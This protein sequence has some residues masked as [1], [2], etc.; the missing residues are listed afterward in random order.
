MVSKPK[1]NVKTLKWVILIEGIEN[2]Q[3][4]ILKMGLLDGYLWFKLKIK[5]GQE[6]DW[7][8]SQ[9]H[10]LKM[11]P[12][13]IIMSKILATYRLW[14]NLNFALMRVIWMIILSL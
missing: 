4:S 13:R 3:I 7:W 8:Q 2:E 5:M 11:L 9:S 10:I 1:T 6:N 14:V 12:C